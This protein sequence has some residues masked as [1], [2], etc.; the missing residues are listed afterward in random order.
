MYRK[1]AVRLPRAPAA[2]GTFRAGGAAFP[3]G[4]TVPEQFPPV[5]QCII[6][7][8]KAA[9]DAAAKRSAALSRT[10]ALRRQRSCPQPGEFHPSG[11]D[12]ACKNPRLHPGRPSEDSAVAR[13]PG[14]HPSGIDRAC[15]N[16]RLHPGRLSESRASVRKHR[17]SLTL[18]AIPAA[19][20]SRPAPGTGYGIRASQAPKPRR[21]T[22]CNAVRTAPSR[23]IRSS[24]CSAAERAPQA[25]A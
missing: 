19:V 25:F 16:P 3:V 4:N 15:K 5:P 2:A 8:H 11:I 21:R 24:F 12:R 14:V 23:A 9:P 17:G 22:R 13:S 18:Q 6:T 7:A 1:H 10:G 20:C